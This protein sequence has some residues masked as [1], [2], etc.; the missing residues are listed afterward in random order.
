M[1]KRA[2]AQAIA[3]VA[4]GLLLAASETKARAQGGEGEEDGPR[5]TA[6]CPPRLIAF[7]GIEKLG[8]EASRLGMLSQTLR[9]TLTVGPDGNPVK[10]ALSRKFRRKYVEIA[11]CRPLL[12]YHRFEPALDANGDPTSGRFTGT[13]DFRMWFRPDGTLTRD[14]RD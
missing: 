9:Y 3:L 12:E 5:C 10:C 14:A 7:D 2:M 8:R 4:G 11:L 6:S 13:I 1:R